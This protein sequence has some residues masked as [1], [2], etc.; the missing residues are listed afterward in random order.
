ML[1]QMWCFFPASVAGRA[2][3]SRHNLMQLSGNDAYKTGVDL[4]S[5]GKYVEAADMFWVS[6]LKVDE[7]AEYDITEAFSNFIQTYAKRDMVDEGFVTV[8]ERYLTSKQV[9]E[10]VHFLRMAHEVR[11]PTVLLHTSYLGCAGDCASRYIHH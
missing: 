3:D 2:R 11:L 7:D 1:A 8:A 10:A 6:V 9:G 4:M 5:V